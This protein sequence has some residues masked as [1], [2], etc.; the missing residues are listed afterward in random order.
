MATK[1]IGTTGRDYA[2]MA[3]WASY[4]NALSLSA[5]ELG[6][7]YNDGT[8]TD[9]AGVTLGG[10]TGGSVTNTVTLRPASGQG[11]RDHANKLTNALRF[12][13]SNG[14][15]FT[16]SL[17]SGTVLTL[18]GAFLTLDGL[19]WKSTGSNNTGINASSATVTITNCILQNDT[20]GSGRVIS[21]NNT[22]SIENT[23]IIAT[24]ASSGGGIECAS[25]SPTI[26]GCTV[27]KLGTA[28]GTGIRRYSSGS[29]VVKNTAVIGWTTDYSGTF[30]ASST[31]N[32]TDKGAFGGTNVS[33][34]GQVS[35]GSSD[36]E[37]LSSGTADLRIKA[38]ST[39]LIDTGATAGSGVDIVNTTR[40]AT[41][42]IGVWEYTAGGGGTPSMFPRRG[43]PSNVLL[44]R[45]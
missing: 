40:G 22:G 35:I 16:N 21:F 11:I 39:K 3:L 31:N 6:E 2:T 4:V 24:G 10:W 17:Y 43:G 19:Q 27:V 1:S 45:F 15:A 30:S 44:T 28:S 5:P 36:F 9:T 41:Y 14:V 29:P 33:T 37:N 13:Q 32:A 20:A 42:D 26:T 34:S 8:I 18:S 7:V 12:N 25:V 38:G 23:L